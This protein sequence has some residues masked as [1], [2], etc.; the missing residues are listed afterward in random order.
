MKIS[1]AGIQSFLRNPGADTAAILLFG[2]DRGLVRERA[3]DL[4]KT[5]VDDL[6]DPFR[7]VEVT[8]LDLKS[9]PPRLLDEAAQLSMTGGRRVIMVDGATDGISSIFVDLLK[10]GTADALVIVEAGIL[11]PASSLRILF[12]KSPKAAAIGCYEDD[13]TALRSVIV[14]TLSRYGLRADTDATSFLIENLGGDRL[15][16]RCELEK[17]ALY[18]GGILDEPGGPK[19]GPPKTVTLEDAMACIGD[20]AGMSLDLIAFA[21]AN[22]DSAGLDRCLE[23]AFNEGTSPIA[24]LRAVVR[25]LERLHLALAMVDNGDSVERALSKLKPP[26]FYKFKSDFLSQMRR[27]QT[28]RLVMALDL[29]LDAEIDCKTTGFPAAAGCHR[30]LMR[31]AQAARSGKTRR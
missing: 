27:W 2:P 12:E 7:V 22:G 5:A 30:A 15:I 6:S 10:A 24:V 31:I 25:H 28:D 16:S 17:L 3:R 4:A 13:G 20:N 9:D 26:V 29:A 21:A 18:A 11:G 19:K 8:G 1:G 23:R 14:E